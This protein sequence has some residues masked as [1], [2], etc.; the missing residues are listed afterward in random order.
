[1]SGV[2]LDKAGDNKHII[3]SDDGKAGLWVGG[4]DDMWKLG[5]PVGVGGP[6]MKSP[7]KA[8]T[9]SD[10]YLMTS[11]DKKELTLESS[12]AATITVEVDISGVGDWYPYK[13]FELQ[14]G[15]ETNYVFPKAFEAYWVRVTSDADTTATA[16]LVYK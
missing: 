11:Y 6:W 10:P 7:V 3:R 16:Q 4:I 5:K 9:P 8:N 14:A 12:N 13:S 15:K 1:M 2:N